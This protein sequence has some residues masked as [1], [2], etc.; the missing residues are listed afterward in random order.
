MKRLYYVIEN[1]NDAEKV[2]ETLHQAGISDW[3]FHVLCQQAEDAELEVHHIHGASL[4]HQLDILH[5]GE[6]GLLIGVAGGVLL[7]TLMYHLS[8]D[9]SWLNWVLVAIACSM[10]GAW[11]GGLIGATKPNY[12]LKHFDKFIKQGKFVAL[13]DT[14]KQQERRIKSILRELPFVTPAGE[15]GLWPWPISTLSLNPKNVG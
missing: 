3:N 5:S 10:F 13:I 9:F 14:A 4:L 6:Q 7:A 1:I 11:S 15:S 2:S 12:Q 8:V